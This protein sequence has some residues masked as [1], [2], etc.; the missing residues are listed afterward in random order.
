MDSNINLE[1]I[2][3]EWDAENFTVDGDLFDKFM[4]STDSVDESDRKRLRTDLDNVENEKSSDNT[5]KDNDSLVPS[6][7]DNYRENNGRPR[8]MTNI[9]RSIESFPVMLRQAVNEGNIP[10]LQ[11]LSRDYVHHGFFVSFSDPLS[12][13]DRTEKYF[14]PK[15]YEALLKAHPDA[16]YSIR[17]IRTFSAANYLCIKCDFRFQGTRVPFDYLDEILERGMARMTSL[18]DRSRISPE[19][20]IKWIELEEKMIAE[21]RNPVLFLKNE[22]T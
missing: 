15:I 12:R 7:F 1:S 14:F 18:F 21:K 22:I 19:N 20:M 11:D 10:F 2:G 8:L 16:V 9:S 13:F 5:Q 4:T 3:L 17:S 6:T